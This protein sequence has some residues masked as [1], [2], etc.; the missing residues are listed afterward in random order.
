MASGKLQRQHRRQTGRV[1]HYKSVPHPLSFC[2]VLI[3]FP[4][5]HHCEADKGLEKI[6]NGVQLLIIVYLPT[7][8]SSKPTR[9]AIFVVVTIKAHLF[10]KI[11]SVLLDHY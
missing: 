4:W 2:S 3:V 1:L 6:G 9:L 5:Q 7:F 11:L 10:T 8:R